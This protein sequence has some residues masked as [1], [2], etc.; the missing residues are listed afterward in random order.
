MEWA[1]SIKPKR[2]N[3]VVVRRVYVP[4]PVR[5]DLGLGGAGRSS[6]AAEN[7]FHIPASGI[8]AAATSSLSCLWLESGRG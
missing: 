6:R 1:F 4:I 8:F 7:A 2:W 5:T 3:Y